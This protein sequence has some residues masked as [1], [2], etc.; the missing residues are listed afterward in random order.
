MRT[1]AN[2]IVKHIRIQPGNMNGVALYKSRIERRSSVNA[3]LLGKIII[4][5]IIHTDV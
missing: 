5:A 3:Q 4:A 2:V 1:G